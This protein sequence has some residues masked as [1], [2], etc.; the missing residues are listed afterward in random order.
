M[1]AS[2]ALMLGIVA[3]DLTGANDCALPMVRLGY[4]ASVLSM[5]PD[6]KALA[7]L[8]AQLTQRPPAGFAPASEKPAVLSLNTQTRSLDAATATERVFQA[9][10]LLLEHTGVESLYKKVDSTLRGHVAYECLA[11]LEAIGGECAFLVPAFPQEGRQTVG[12]YHLLRGQPL[13]R[14]EAARDPQNPVNASFIPGMLK[15]LLPQQP[16]WIGHIGLKKV[17]GGAGPLLQAMTEAIKEGQ[18]LVVI[19]AAGD[20]D[21][22]QIALALERLRQQHRVLPCGAA[23]LMQAMTRVCGSQRQTVTQTNTLPGIPARPILVMNGSNTPM[24]R[25]QMV[26]LCDPTTRIDDTVPVHRL[27]LTPEQLLGLAS[28]AP[29][30]SDIQQQVAANHTVVVNTAPTESSVAQTQALGETH[31]LNAPAT[32]RQVQFTLRQLVGQLA[33]LPVQWVF[34]GGETSFQAGLALHQ[35]KLGQQ[36]EDGHPGNPPVHW[37][38]GFQW[39]ILAELS[40]NIPLCQDAAGRWL[41]SKSGNFG[42]PDTLIELVRQLKRLEV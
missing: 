37:E 21:L 22:E 24:G 1:M 31:G 41:V 12:G 25:Q 39:Q 32:H 6:S 33:T 29:V 27:D 8:H 40:P 2:T 38:Q 9:T 36:Q 42:H 5:S 26:R 11:T 16:Q 23:G 34:C 18:R 13:E 7:G 3:D 17:M 28:L 20:V 30:V 19:D 35:S 4:Q 10:R 15:R 14:T